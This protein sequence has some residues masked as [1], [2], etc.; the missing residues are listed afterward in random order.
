LITTVDI[1]VALLVV[2]FLLAVRRE[3]HQ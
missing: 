2:G 1:I 3:A